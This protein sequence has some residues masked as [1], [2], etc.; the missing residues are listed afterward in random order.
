MQWNS[1]KY[2]MLLLKV[3]SLTSSDYEQTSPAQDSG[4]TG[5]F[6]TGDNGGDLFVVGGAFGNACI[7][8]A[9][10]FHIDGWKSEDC[11]KAECSG[12]PEP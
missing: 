10:D 12:T 2:G 5:L 6:S 8:A 4:V 9:R 7:T 11:V 1:P 3:W